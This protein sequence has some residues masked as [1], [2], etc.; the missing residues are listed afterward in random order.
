M[1]RIINVE[2]VREK[3]LIAVDNNSLYIIIEN[4]Y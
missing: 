4:L 1:N 3:W 2:L